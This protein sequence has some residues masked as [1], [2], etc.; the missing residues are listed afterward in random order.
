MDPI[1]KE[2]MG[3]ATSIFN[4][5]RNIGGSMGI[6][7]ATT[8]L[9]R[10]TQSHI[11]VLGAHVNPYNPQAQQM[12][13]DLRAAFMAHGADPTTAT[14]QATAAL[15]GMVQ[16]QASMLAF[17]QTFLV[18]AILFLAAMPLLLL[19]RRPTHRG[20]GIPVH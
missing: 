10:D 15:W 7:A 13:Q 19:M 16:Q 11:N 4:L 5:M 9:E 3:N 12:L 14:S 8:L 20:G 6:A 2:E 18:L 17:G 1:S